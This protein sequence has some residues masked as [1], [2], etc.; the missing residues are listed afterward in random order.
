[1]LPLDFI[2]LNIYFC[3]RTKSNMLRF[4]SSKYLLLW[5]NKSDG[6]GFHSAKYLLLWQNKIRSRWI[7]FCQIFT[8]VAEQNLMSL[9]SI[10]PN[11]YFCGRTESNMLGFHSSKYLLL[12]QNKSD[13]LGFHSFKYLLL[14][15]N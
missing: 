14:C 8:S 15:Q 6:F 10:L 7:P 1:M 5:Q 13:G 11:I 4:H 12:W 3:G 9:D 2:L